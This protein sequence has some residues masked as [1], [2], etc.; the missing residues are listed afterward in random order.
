MRIQKE[1]M[2]QALEENRVQLHELRLEIS[3]MRVSF[4]RP[5]AVLSLAKSH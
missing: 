5:T 4:E 3:A 1:A 2:C